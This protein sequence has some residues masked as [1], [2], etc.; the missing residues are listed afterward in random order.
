MT[1]VLSVLMI[2]AMAVQVIRP[3]GIYGLRKRSDFWKIAA[4]ALILFGV[5]ALIRPE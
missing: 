1:K 5:I 4:F 3:I 2:L